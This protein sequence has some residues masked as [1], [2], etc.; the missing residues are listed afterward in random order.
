MQM[1]DYGIQMEKSTQSKHFFLFSFNF[2]S[3]GSSV[4]TWNEQKRRKKKQAQNGTF[5]HLVL[6]S[7]LCE[8]RVEKARSEEAQKT[9]TNIKKRKSAR[10]LRKSMVKKLI[11]TSFSSTVFDGFEQ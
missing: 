4:G 9:N 2:H 11:K 8:K 1:I 5:S 6:K 7:I 10:E 3:F